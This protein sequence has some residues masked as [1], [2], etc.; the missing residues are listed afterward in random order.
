M[1]AGKRRC[2]RPKQHW[3]HYAK[4]TAY[5][6]HVHGSDYTESVEHDFRIY[7]AALNRILM[8][9][10]SMVPWLRQRLA[11]F[12]DASLQ[13]MA[14]KKMQVTHA[15]THTHIYIYIYIYRII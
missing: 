8:V 7:N 13:G 12:E 10:F 5:E 15:H 2:G 4:K 9:L 11:S 1:N 3:L 6:M 14:V